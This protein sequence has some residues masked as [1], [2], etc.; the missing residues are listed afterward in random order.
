LERAIADLRK[1]PYDDAIHQIDE[2]DTDPL[3]WAMARVRA[4][5]G[6]NS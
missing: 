6:S 5:L 1:V 4:R 3:R 2:G